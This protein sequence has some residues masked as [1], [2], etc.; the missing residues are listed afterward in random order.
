MIE[1]LGDV[2]VG[3]QECYGSYLKECCKLAR[4]VVPD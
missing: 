3:G 4:E 1:K 2:I